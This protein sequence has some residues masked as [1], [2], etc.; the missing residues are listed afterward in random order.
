MKNKFSIPSLSPT[1]LL[2]GIRGDK[3]ISETI[4][5][6]SPILNRPVKLEVV[7]P[8][9]VLPGISYPLLFL[10]DGQDCEGIRLKQ[11]LERLW[12]RNEIV[13]IIVVGIHAGDRMQEYGV[14]TEKDFSGRGAKAS[15]YSDFIVKELLLFIQSRYPIDKNKQAIGGFSLGALSAMDIALSHPEVF[16]MMGAF[17]GSFWWRRIDASD[18]AFDEKKDRIMHNLVREIEKCEG[19][20]FWFQTG[21]RDEQHDRNG[22]GVIDSIDD[23]LDLI[24]ELTK[25]GYRP[26]HDIVYHEIKGG[27]HNQHTWGEAM[28]H[29]LKWAFPVR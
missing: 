15:L 5:S 25:K 16:S 11:S 18:K 8:Q 24:S 27:E 20:K 1:S 7:R 23:T 13:P 12:H 10:N 21:T 4:V 14:A 22:N 9:N 2:R 29:F 17:S 26:F 3:Y 6:H 19:L 28:P